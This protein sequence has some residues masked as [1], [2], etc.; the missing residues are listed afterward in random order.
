[1]STNNAENDVI[2][3]VEA[4]EPE[5]E[6]LMTFR[7]ALIWAAVISVFA[8]L[9]GGL[10][11]RPNLDSKTVPE[12]LVGEWTS[13]HPEYS[14]RYLTMTSKSITFGTGGTSFVKYTILGIEEEQIEGVDKIIL[15]F[16]DVAG[17]KFKRTMVVESPGARMYFESQPAVIWQ[18]VGT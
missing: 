3:E 14:D 8:L 9:A 12:S 7:R 15:H 2:V 1:M 17:T 11:D 10:F 4:H 5:P 18:R 13:D 6:R 16:R